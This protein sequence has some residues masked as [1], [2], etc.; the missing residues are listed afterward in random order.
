[1]YK[2]VNKKRSIPQNCAQHVPPA[3]S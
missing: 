2:H 3:T 1:M